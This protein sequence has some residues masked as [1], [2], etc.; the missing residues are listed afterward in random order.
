MN[1]A[2]FENDRD[3][4]Y[5]TFDFSITQSIELKEGGGVFIPLPVPGDVSEVDTNII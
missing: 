5:V 2:D 1:R 4:R 3:L